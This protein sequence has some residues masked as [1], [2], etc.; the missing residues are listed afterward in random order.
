MTQINAAYT[1]PLPSPPVI[2]GRIELLIVV[3]DLKHEES[4]N[5]ANGR[6]LYIEYPYGK[7]IRIDQREEPAPLD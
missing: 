5:V 1:L 4:I 2:S 6:Y 3:G 7:R